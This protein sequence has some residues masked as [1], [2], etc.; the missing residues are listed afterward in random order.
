MSSWW[1]GAY[2]VPAL[3]SP[4]FESEMPEDQEDEHVTATPIG[5]SGAASTIVQWVN[6]PSL[7]ATLRGW[8]SAA[9]KSQILARRKA[10]FSVMT[11]FDTTGKLWYL[12]SARFVRWTQQEPVAVA[13]TGER[14]FYTMELIGR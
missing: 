2:E 12:M 5:A 7:K 4:W 9:T 11:P 6:R 1:F 8:C 3:D 10:T 14:F 13:G